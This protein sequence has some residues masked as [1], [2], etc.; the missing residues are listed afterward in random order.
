[1]GGVLASPLSRADTHWMAKNKAATRHRI[2]LGSEHRHKVGQPS[3]LLLC[4][5][6]ASGQ[7][8]T[9]KEE[10]MTVRS[11]WITSVILQYLGIGEGD[12]NHL[13]WA[14]LGQ[15]AQLVQ[16]QIWLHATESKSGRSRPCP[17]L[18]CN[19]PA[20][21]EACCWEG[22]GIANMGA[23]P[24]HHP[25]DISA[26]CPAMQQQSF[27][28]KLLCMCEKCYACCMYVSDTFNKL[29]CRQGD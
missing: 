28:Y 4:R 13:A 20:I 8:E 18:S 10:D 22:K 19:C 9:R 24:S 15:S 16:F 7:S 14:E 12:P 17:L 11:L 29:E 26:R 2:I 25:C 5:R 27:S 6:S 21:S 1:M 3:D 23:H